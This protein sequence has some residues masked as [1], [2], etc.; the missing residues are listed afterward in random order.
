MLFVV[1]TTG[2]TIAQNAA[3]KGSALPESALVARVRALNNSVLHLHEQMQQSGPSGADSICG[4]A[5]PFLA[6]RAAALTQLI[7][8]DPHTALT[9]AFSPELL[10]DLAAKFPSATPQLEQHVTLNGS[11]EHWIADSADMKS[12]TESWFLNAGGSRLSLYFATPQRPAPN[13]GPVVTIEGMQVGNQ[14]AVSKVLT[15]PIGGASSMF[16]KGLVGTRPPVSL[17]AV[18]LMSL[19]LVTA[20]RIRVFDWLRASVPTLPRSGRGRYSSLTKRFAACVVALLL[21]VFSPLPTSAQTCGTT[22]PQ[23]IAVIVVTFPGV[24]VP[25]SITASSLGSL[26]FNTTTDPSLNR[27]WTEASYG[28]SSAVGTVVGPYTLSGFYSCSN[29][30]QL[31]TDAINAAIAGGVNISNYSRVSIVFPGFSPS[32]GLDGLST[33]GCQAFSTSVGSITVSASLLVW[34]SIAQ[35]PTGLGIEI[36]IHENGHQ[37]G[38]GHAQLRT[39][40][41]TDLSTDT[42]SIPLAPVGETCSYPTG[43]SG[44]QNGCVVFEYADDFSVMGASNTNGTSTGHVAAG[45]KAEQLGWLTPS[46]YQIVSNSGTYTIEPYETSPAGVKAL[47]IQRGGTNQNAWIWVEYRQPI[48]YDAVLYPTQIFGGALIH[49]QEPDTP[50]YTRLLD[51]TSPATYSNNPALVVGQTWTDPYSNVSISVLS[52]TSSGLTVSVNYG[53]TPCTLSAPSVSLSPLDPSIYAGQTASYSVTVTDNDSSGCSSDTFNVASSAPSGWSTSLSSSSVTLSPGQSTTVTVGKG[54]PSGTPVGT[55]AVNLSA[56]STSSTATGSANATVMASPSLAVSVSTN[57]STFTPP[58]TVSI[59]ATVTNGG[60]PASGASVTFSL[61]APNG[62]NTTQTATTGASGI[63]TWNYKL[64]S[65]SLVGTYSV[66]AQAALSSGSGGK[67]GTASTSTQTA[68]SNTASFT[69]Q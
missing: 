50:P 15:T 45:H 33:I 46:N 48:G 38:L 20:C 69:V 64:S 26:F 56:S 12:S 62:S 5:G 30:F 16:P 21:V 19:V 17:L 8:T 60:T 2:A 55:Y 18:L 42:G 44:T 53:V 31:V 68:T 41:T 14:V 43:S 61:T 40:G 1:I 4:M 7:Q 11:I 25:S 29:Q 67:K 24:S 27:Y 3:P 28:Q 47:K 6:Q 10:A 65:K 63:A 37:L 52:A 13:A 66:S 35:N 59:T 34:D 51:F 9:F 36:I 39:D 22:G 54:A 49:Y 57:A 58:S 23:S 32:C